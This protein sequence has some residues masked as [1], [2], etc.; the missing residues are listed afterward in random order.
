[1]S[2]ARR[3]VEEILRPEDAAGEELVLASRSARRSM[4]LKM[5]GVPFRVVAPPE[6]EPGPRRVS[7]PADYAVQR[8]VEKCRAV[9][10]ELSAPA[11]VLGAD[12]IVLLDGEVLEKPRGAA[13]ARRHLMRLSAREHEVVTGIVLHRRPQGRE[14]AGY[15][16]T[17][18]RMAPLDA[19]TVAR[20]VATGEPLDKA[21]AYGIQGIGSLLVTAIDGCYFNVVGLPLARLRR[22]FLTLDR[23]R[24]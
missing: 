6:D 16:T 20:Y 7:D 2:V 22:L 5:L 13:E 14:A 17:R 9:A 1:M 11:V 10:R 24:A 15:E 8:A 18:V 3:L 4:L 19:E 23:D 12:T 21:G